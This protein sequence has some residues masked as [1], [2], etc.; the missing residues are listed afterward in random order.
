MP[1]GIP[2]HWVVFLSFWAPSGTGGRGIFSKYF[3]ST[4][5]PATTTQII[6]NNPC[7]MLAFDIQTFLP[8]LQKD[9]RRQCLRTPVKICRSE[10]CRSIVC[11]SCFS[12]RGSMDFG[13]SEV[14]SR[15]LQKWY[16][17]PDAIYP[18]DSTLMKWSGDADITSGYN[19]ILPWSHISW[20]Y[21]WVPAISL[22]DIWVSSSLYISLE[23]LYHIFA[24]CHSFF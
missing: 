22:E 9:W 4:F 3:P 21:V 23:T 12:M 17:T 5:H 16:V 6:Y 11:S 24:D 2:P 10:T 13:W 1:C 18:P 19:F 14:K 7:H 15:M 20:F 8:V